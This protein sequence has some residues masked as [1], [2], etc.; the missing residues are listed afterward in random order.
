MVKIMIAPKETIW[1]V[2]CKHTGARVDELFCLSRSWYPKD[3]LYIYQFCIGRFSIVY[4]NEREKVLKN[5][6]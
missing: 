6:T 4:F 5:E 1:W 3:R 2:R